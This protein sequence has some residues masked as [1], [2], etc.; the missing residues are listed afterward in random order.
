L[1]PA[2]RNRHALITIGT[3]LQRPC[4]YP[5]FNAG[6]RL[7]L[8]RPLALLEMMLLLATLIIDF[9]FEF[10]G[11]HD[12]SYVARM[13]CAPTPTKPGLQRYRSCFMGFSKHIL[14]PNTNHMIHVSSPSTIWG[15]KVHY[16]SRKLAEVRAQS[17]G[18]ATRNSAVNTQR[19]MVLMLFTAIVRYES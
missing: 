13:L 5:V 2:Y 1:I 6:P 18:N 19:S 8:G 4:R 3:P 9:D 16:V 14:K 7:C 10:D 12:A 11:P 17:Q 15:V